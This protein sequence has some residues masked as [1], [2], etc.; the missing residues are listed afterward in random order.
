VVSSR[1]NKANMT[2]LAYEKR[3]RASNVAD[4]PS[5]LDEATEWRTPDV[6]FDAYAEIDLGGR[7]VELW[8][9]GPGNGPGDTVVHVPDAKVAWTGNFVCAAGLNVLNTYRLHEQA[10]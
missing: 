7:V 10:G 8:Q 4:D 2:D 6:V 1:L 9:F 3:V 5:V